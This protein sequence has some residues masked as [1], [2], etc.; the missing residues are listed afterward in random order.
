[1]ISMTHKMPLDIPKN[2]I[3]QVMGTS[4]SPKQKKLILFAVIEK[5]YVD[6]IF[7]KKFDN[8]KEVNWNY[9]TRS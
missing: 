8:I 4:F 1:M 6:F 5:I 7:E 3:S 2:K 9:V